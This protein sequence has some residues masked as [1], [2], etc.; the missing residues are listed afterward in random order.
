MIC[1]DD[2]TLDGLG[3]PMMENVKYTLKSDF[4]VIDLG[5]LHWLLEIQIKIRPKS[6]EL[7]QIAHIESILSR[8]GLQDCN[9]SV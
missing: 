3:G 1:V 2:I 7:S 5:D 4:K 8:F 6:I 9:P